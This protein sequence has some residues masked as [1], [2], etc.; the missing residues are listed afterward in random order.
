[1][2]LYAG[3]AKEIAKVE[4][5]SAKLVTFMLIS[6]LSKSFATEISIKHNYK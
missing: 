4:Y 1:M 3:S 2:V 6:K 5:S